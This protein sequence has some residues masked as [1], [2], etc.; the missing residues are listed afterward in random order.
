MTDAPTPYA[1]SHIY[2]TCS[3]LGI[4]RPQLQSLATRI[5]RDIVTPLLDSGSTYR[6]HPP[7]HSGGDELRLH[8]IPGPDKASPSEIIS[9]LHTLL[10]FLTHSV[11]PSDTQVTER[12]PFLTDLTSTMLSSLLHDVLIPSMPSTIS[13]IPQWLSIL[14]E[15]A[16]LESSS[17]LPTGQWV[18]RPF[19]DRQAGEEWV[20][21]R[22]RQAAEH[23]KRLVLDGWGGWDAKE[24]KREKEVRVMVEAEVDVPLEQY[25][26]T[27][28]KETT[29][30]MAEGAEEEGHG[31][32]FDSPVQEKADL[33]SEPDKPSSPQ[34]EPKQEAE[35]TDAWGFD[36]D[37]ASP[38][39]TF[40][41]VP[42]TREEGDDGWDFDLIPD[43]PKPVAQPVKPGKPVREAKKLGKK[44]AKAKAV[45]EDD[46][47]SGRDELDFTHNSNVDE[48]EQEHGWGWD[49]PIPDD[50]KASERP[51]S[52][53]QKDSTTTTVPAPQKQTILREERRTVEETYLVSKTCDRLLEIVERCLT[54]SKDLSTSS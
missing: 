22:R 39:S 53:G 11:F 46:P 32:G 44:V 19:I 9:S 35:E 41:S 12:N 27:Q 21:S 45:E 20:N 54:E 26:R 40:T 24:V 33:K 16:S 10:D 31:W 36:D 28:G 43:E 49:E 18:I 47:M 51:G 23:V 17:T 52:S 34:L 30:G 25:E 13:D 38:T 48:K 42:K 3:R 1:L 4:L 14:G 29:E 8:L 15:A 2:T 7:S 50:A 5:K 37:P 6:I